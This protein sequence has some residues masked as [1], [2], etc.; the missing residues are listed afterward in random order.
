MENVFMF[1]F[2]FTPAPLADSRRVKR[3]A[4]LK[5][6]SRAAQGCGEEYSYP[7]TTNF[8]PVIDQ[9]DPDPDDGW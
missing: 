5:G 9:T 3:V 7:Q 1:R 2:L 6:F 8:G 4:A